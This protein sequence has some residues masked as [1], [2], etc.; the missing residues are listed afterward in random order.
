MATVSTPSYRKRLMYHA[1]LLGGMGL[2]AS[3]ILVLGNISTRNDIELRIKE[4]IKASINQ[5]IPETMYD[6]DLLDDSVLIESS[7]AISENK[8]TKVYLARTQNKVTAAAFQVTGT[9]YA[10]PIDII[11]G[12]DAHEKLL[13]VR[14]IA[15]AE[16]PGL[17]DR[18]EIKKDNW[19]AKFTGLSLSNT[20]KEKWKV[21]K[22]GGV[23]D[24]FSGATITPRAVV[25]AIHNGLLFF[26]ENKQ[27][28][29]RGT[30]SG[31]TNTNTV[32]TGG[33]NE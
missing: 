20:S 14:V 5:V 19:I 8:N 18:I 2:L 7:H 31:S 13:G 11:I 27:Q 30:S 33:K 22:D 24:Q 3:A 17:G 16:T 26:S 23:F 4:D 15:H 1:G 25:K 29:L 32:D 12:I 6:N 21:K 10:G 28:I 9:G